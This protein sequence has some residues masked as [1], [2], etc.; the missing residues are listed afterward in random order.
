MY[1]S[2]VCINL[3]FYGKKLKISANRFNEN[4]L[5]FEDQNNS[6]LLR[7]KIILNAALSTGESK[8]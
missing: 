4:A 3:L 5:D 8:F 2:Y 6:Y 1:Y 7:K